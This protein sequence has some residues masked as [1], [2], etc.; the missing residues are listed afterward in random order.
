MTDMNYM[1]ASARDD[2]IKLLDLRMNQVMLTCRWVTA[3]IRHHHHPQKPY[4]LVQQDTA[5][6][7]ISHL[8]QLTD[9]LYIISLSAD[10]FKVAM[11]HTRASFRYQALLVHVFCVNKIIVYSI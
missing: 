6:Y 7:F 10:G 1:L 4:H 8:P 9:R 5:F 11:D 3:L 2:T